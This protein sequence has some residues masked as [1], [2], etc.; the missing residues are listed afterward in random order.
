MS[1]HTDEDLERF[2]DKMRSIPID[3]TARSVGAYF[4][5]MKNRD[6]RKAY[7]KWKMRQTL[8]ERDKVAP[9]IPSAADYVKAIVETKYTNDNEVAR[10]TGML[11]LPAFP[12]IGLGTHVNCG[13]R[14]APNPELLAPTFEDLV[15]R[16]G[17]KHDV[18]PYIFLGVNKNVEPLP[19]DEMREGTQKESNSSKSN[20]STDATS[21]NDESGFVF[22]QLGKLEYV[23]ADSWDADAAV[24]D[25]KRLFWWDTGYVVVIVID[26]DGNGKDIHLLYN[27]RPQDEEDGKRYQVDDSAWGWLPGDPI[28]RAG[29]KLAGR[30]SDLQ[31]G[32]P[33]HI[34]DLEKDKDIERTLIKREFELVQAVKEGSPPKIVREIVPGPLA[35]HGNDERKVM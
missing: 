9:S 18:L 34:P 17:P 15:R 5:V 1:S 14:L 7:N 21:N 10:L 27:F 30:F 26:S 12:Y 23:P 2:H 22:Y 6:D 4:S 29:V 8:K 25:P 35:K 24:Q 28:R 33:I 32:Y 16:P 20:H 19:M 3:E 11:S 13:F 31:H